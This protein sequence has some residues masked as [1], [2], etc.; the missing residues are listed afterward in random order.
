MTRRRPTVVRACRLAAVVVSLAGYLAAAIGF[1][2][3]VRSDGATGEAACAG[4]LCGCPA[5]LRQRHEC[6]CEKGVARSAPAPRPCCQSSPE[7]AARRACCQSE[8]EPAAAA[9]PHCRQEAA[10]AED[11]GSCCQA[12]ASEPPVFRVRFVLGE[13][14]QKCRGL[15]TLWVQA[16]AALPPPVTAACAADPEPAGRVAALQENPLVTA[17]RPPT[18]PPRR[19]AC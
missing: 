7:P 19:A 2:V 3:P 5:E 12:A 8:P 11:G 1:P 9:G 16:G 15:S 13:P 10:E 14:L 17:V 18:P 6:C 4:G